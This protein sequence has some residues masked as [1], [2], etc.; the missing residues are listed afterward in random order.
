MQ[1]QGPK[2]DASVRE[3]LNNYL[4]WRNGS[5][6]IKLRA[7]TV[8]SQ[9]P[10]EAF[11]LATAVSA[12]PVGH[13]IWVLVKEGG[14]GDG[15]ADVEDN[16]RDPPIPDLGRLPQARKRDEAL[17]HEMRKKFIHIN[18]SVLAHCPGVSLNG[19]ILSPT[20]L[21]T[22]KA[23]WVATTPARRGG[24][25][26][27]TSTM[28]L[29]NLGGPIVTS[30]WQSSLTIPF[31]KAAGGVDPATG[32]VAVFYDSH[33]DIYDGATLTLQQRIEVPESASSARQVLL[34]PR[35]A[36]IMD[37][38]SKL[39]VVARGPSSSSAPPSWY[40]VPLATR[41]A[42]DAGRP[43][44]LFVGTLQGHVHW[45]RINEATLALT[46]HGTMCRERVAGRI[47]QKL[48]VQDNH[49][50]AHC[51]NIIAMYNMLDPE[52]DFTVELAT[53]TKTE[54]KQ[55][56][57]RIFMSHI[58]MGWGLLVGVNPTN[59]AILVI[60]LDKTED[61]RIIPQ[62]TATA[63]AAARYTDKATDIT[64]FTGKYL[65]LMNHDLSLTQFG[66]YST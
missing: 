59:D 15:G 30:V 25:D 29:I 19:T 34:S 12:V 36:I 35:L 26:S 22:L 31:D 13:Y 6:D 42:F 38:H 58:T 32:D 5:A 8:P 27:L 52:A 7:R 54:A 9:W 50:M 10:K 23:W 4:A 37:T 24:G 41:I 45:L 60:D 40:H 46:R 62:N 18:E 17:W 3:A 11:G 47:V 14:D 21:E 33:L 49:I 64:M 48:A 39:H 2:T 57:K 16:V 53:R 43:L 61:R 55:S 51:G 56:G 44:N 66:L 20:D 28:G 65:F 63:A 1:S